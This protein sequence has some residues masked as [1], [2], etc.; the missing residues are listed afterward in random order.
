MYHTT[1][2]SYDSRRRMLSPGWGATIAALTT[3][4]VVPVI[5]TMVLLYP[6]LVVGILAGATLSF[7]LRNTSRLSGRLAGDDPGPLLQGFSSYRMRLKHRGL[8]NSAQ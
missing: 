5:I 8:S 2:E 7:G 3:A 4:I 6:S 1:L